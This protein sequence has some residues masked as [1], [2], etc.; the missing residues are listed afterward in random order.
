MQGDLY[1]LY[2][3]NGMQTYAFRASGVIRHGDTVH[4]LKREVR[5]KVAAQ[6]RQRREKARQ[7]REIRKAQL[8]VR[9]VENADFPVRWQDAR[10]LHYCAA[11]IREWLRAYAPEFEHSE[12]APY[13]KLRKLMDTDKRV[14][15]VLETAVLRELSV[16]EG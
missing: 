11:G 14:R 6:N 13:H 10:N 15:T 8:I 12:S 2:T 9:L 3:E 5:H 7:R 4:W 16:R 1:A